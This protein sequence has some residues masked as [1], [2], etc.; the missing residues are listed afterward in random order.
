MKTILILTITGM[1]LA[2]SFLRE[3]SWLRG[4]GKISQVILNLDDFNSIDIQSSIDVVVAYGD[5]QEVLAKGPA[6]IIRKMLT[7]VNNGTWKVG[8]EQGCRKNSRLTVYITVPDLKKVEMNGTGDVQI[9]D[10]TDLA[11]MSIENRGSGKINLESLA[12][13]GTLDIKIPG[14]D[15][16]RFARWIDYLRHFRR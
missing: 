4:E 1:L 13:S 11:D 8:L 9:N 3:S 14:S 2:I 6:T 5:K 16:G 12:G 7:R 10:F 15:S